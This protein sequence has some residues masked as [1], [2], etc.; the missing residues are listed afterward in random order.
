MTA[1]SLF[2]G[3]RSPA[4]PSL[5]RYAKALFAQENVWMPE[6]EADLKGVI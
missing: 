4:Y 5:S 2:K 1:N 3:A 6:N